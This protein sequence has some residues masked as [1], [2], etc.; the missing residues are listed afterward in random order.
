MAR[1]YAIE[2]PGKGRYSLNEQALSHYCANP[3]EEWGIKPGDFVPGRQCCF[4]PH[5]GDCD[6]TRYEID[7]IL[8]DNS[9]E[10][11]YVVIGGNDERYLWTRGMTLEHFAPN[12]GYTKKTRW[13]GPGA[14]TPEE[15][16]SIEDDEEYEK[17]L[18][19]AKSAQWAWVHDNIGPSPVCTQGMKNGDTIITALKWNAS[20]KQVESTGGWLAGTLIIVE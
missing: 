19:L 20:G 4:D 10:F 5:D 17:A 11:S 12:S 7:N 15:I 1:A 13:P 6:A 2:I 16:T 3:P 8:S 9:Q 18:A 14:T